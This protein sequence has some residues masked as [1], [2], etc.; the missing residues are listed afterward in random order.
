[1]DSS[2]VPVSRR[3]GEG[4]TN[5]G[6]REPLQVCVVVLAS[7]GSNGHLIPAGVSGTSWNKVLY[8][9][10]H[11]RGKNSPLLPPLLAKGDPHFLVAG[12]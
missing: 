9:Q 2:V 10:D 6:Q 12:P 11:G 3:K 4:E 7:P 5:L 1:M 8:S